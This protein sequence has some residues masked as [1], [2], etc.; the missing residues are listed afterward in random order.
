[1]KTSLLISTFMCMFI[2][3]LSY[4]QVEQGNRSL[5]ISGEIALSQNIFNPLINLNITLLAEDGKVLASSTTDNKGFFKFDQLDAYKIYMIKLDENNSAIS[6]FKK[7]ELID[8]KAGIIRETGIDGI[9]GKLVFR[10][11]PVKPNSLPQVAAV[12]NAPPCIDL[13]GS[14]IGE[15]KSP[16][17]N[18]TVSLMNENGQIVRST[19]TDM[20]GIFK[21]L[22]IPADQYL[23]LVLD[24]NDNQFKKFNKIFLTDFKGIVVK[25][26]KRGVHGFKFSILPTEKKK[27]EVEYVEDPWLKV[28]QLKTKSAKE[29]HAINESNIASKDS[30]GENT[31]TIVEN[32]YYNTGE[33]EVSP[34]VSKI[35]DKLIEIMKKDTLLVVQIGSHTD[36]RASEDYNF[37][38]SVQRATTAVDYIIKNGIASR[39]VTGKGY[40]ES[41]L[42][43]KCADG[44]ECSE[45]EHA[46]NRRTEFKI[47]R[48]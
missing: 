4:A 31:I 16:I 30:K 29:N 36:S 48:E 34:E 19:K 33:F 21:F 42:I 1:M 40:G 35:L 3:T 43:N 47:S 26:I 14:F 17:A 39:R 2:C 37:K 22:N 24:E 20:Y 38:L 8:I 6:I 5:S 44:V 18:S 13:K 23:L 32:I 27:L 10:N 11:L 25:E 46:K 15:D 9:G 28:L 41:R 12:E 7:Y 45:E